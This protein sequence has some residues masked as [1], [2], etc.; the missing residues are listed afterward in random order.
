MKRMRRQEY[1]TVQIPIK[2]VRRFEA[3]A[4]KLGVSRATVIRWA[5]AAYDLSSLPNGSKTSTV[6]SQQ[7]ADADLQPA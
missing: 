4:K 2:D 6:A 5:L 7:P 3:A 1:T